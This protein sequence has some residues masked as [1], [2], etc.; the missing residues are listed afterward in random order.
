MLLNTDPT[1]NKPQQQD[2]LDRWLSEHGGIFYK[3][4]RVY[5]FNHHDREDLFQEIVLQ[6]WNS[7]PNFNLIDFV[8]AEILVHVA[9]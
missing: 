7:I 3:L 8:D 6:V 2:T 9:P 1:M 5:A 4:V